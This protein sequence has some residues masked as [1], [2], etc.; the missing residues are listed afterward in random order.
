MNTKVLPIAKPKVLGFLHHAFPLSIIGNYTDYIPWFHNNFIQILC[1]T[2]YFENKNDHLVDFYFPNDPLFSYPCLETYASK[3]EFSNVQTNIVDFVINSI[4]KD[5]YV[6]THVDEFYI[7]HRNVHNQFHHTHNIFVYGYENGNFNVLGF[8]ENQNFAS[9]QV[10]FEEFSE[11]YAHANYKLS[12]LYNYN[13]YVIPQ[14]NIYNVIRS[15]K[16]YLSSVNTVHGNSYL[17]LN[18]IFGIKAYDYLKKYVETIK[19]DSTRADIRPF[20]LLLEHKIC[21]LERIAYLE[22]NN[23]LT[24]SNLDKEYKEIVQL[25]QDQR[26]II[27]KY[28]LIKD[29]SLLLKLVSSIDVLITQ[30]KTILNK[31]IRNL[32]LSGFST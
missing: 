1:N 17:P 29:D 24:N 16:D 30:E 23:F 2:E 8:D 26:N 7:P 22:E 31:L 15:I 13:N 4:N 3:P 9:T 19:Q 21:M 14:F 25:A 28:T 20:H 12:I 11:G 18:P 10:T 32:E 5:C 6:Y 27:L